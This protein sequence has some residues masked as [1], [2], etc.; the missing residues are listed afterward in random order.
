MGPQTLAVFPYDD[1]RVGGALL[2]AP[3]APAPS[4]DGIVIYLNAA[5][6]LDAV[7]SRAAELGAKVLL[8]KL[9]LPGDIGAIAHIVDSEGNRIGLHSPNA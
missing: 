2:Q 1:G 4:T 7:L 6:S 9:Q 8:A 5:P 3:G